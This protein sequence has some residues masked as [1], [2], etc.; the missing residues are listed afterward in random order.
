M[1]IFLMMCF[2]FIGGWSIAANFNTQKEERERQEIEYRLQ[3]REYL[4]NKSRDLIKDG[5]IR[6]DVIME[7]LSL[8]DKINLLIKT[9]T[10]KS[11]EVDKSD[12]YKNIQ[13]EGK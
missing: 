6:N 11:D 10:V 5:R 12:Y 4:Y 8:E 3:K 2:A 1:F 13:K 9:L 7:N